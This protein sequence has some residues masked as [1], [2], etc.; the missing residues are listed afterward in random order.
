DFSARRWMM[1]ALQHLW[2]RSFG[3]PLL[4]VCLLLV[5]LAGGSGAAE[6]SDFLRKLFLRQM[7]KDLAERHPETF[8][9]AVE[10]LDWDEHEVAAAEKAEQELEK[11]HNGA[12]CTPHLVQP[13]AKYAFVHLRETES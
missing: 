12:G 10:E 8:G 1:S 5:S 7:Y 3:R 11:R 4:V 13:V 2:P 6:G 9:G